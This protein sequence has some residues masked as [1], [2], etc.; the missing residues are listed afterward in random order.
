MHVL[1]DIGGTNTRIAVTRDTQSFEEPVI[2]S[3]PQNFDA[4]F[5][6]AS[7]TIVKITQGKSVSTV[8]IGMAGTFSEDRST[9]HMSPHLPTWNG[10]NIKEKIHS[11]FSCDVILENDTALV[12]LGEALY[13]SGKGYDIVVYITISTG[14]GGVRIVDGHVDRNKIGFEIGHQIVNEDK[15][16]EY[17]LAGSSHQARFGKPS[18]EIKD[19]LFWKEVD[20]YTGILAANTTMFWSPA[21]IIFGGP[22]VNDINMDN[23]IATAKQF[24]T[25]YETLPK[26]VK[27]SLGSLGGLYG[28]LVLLQGKV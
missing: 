1:I 27:S 8:V 14:V 2:F 15:E 3:T 21:V 26:I 5:S 25:M 23:V 11:A 6:I 16:L 12:G 9:I 20:H 10:L 17:Y 19:L 24:T 22:V 28:G 13:G 7:E 18:H 4:W